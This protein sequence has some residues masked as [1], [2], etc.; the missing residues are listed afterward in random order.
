MIAHRD[1]FGKSRYHPVCNDIDFVSLPLQL[2]VNV[3]KTDHLMGEQLRH[4]RGFPPSQ[5]KTL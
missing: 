4:K 1:D 2:S 3:D 5:G